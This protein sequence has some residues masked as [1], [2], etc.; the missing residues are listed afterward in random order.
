MKSNAGDLSSFLKLRA[1]IVQEIGRPGNIFFTSS[2]D[3]PRLFSSVPAEAPAMTL[4]IC[5]KNEGEKWTRREDR[6]SQL[7]FFAFFLVVEGLDW[8]FCECLRKIFEGVAVYWFSI[9]QQRRFCEWWLWFFIHRYSWKFNN[10]HHDFS[11]FVK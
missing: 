10:G 6:I 2:L 8:R 5:G 4:F 3:T 1:R 7:C 11:L 9:S